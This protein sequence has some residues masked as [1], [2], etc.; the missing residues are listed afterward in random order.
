MTNGCET[1]IMTKQHTSKVQTAKIKYIKQ[2]GERSD[3][4]DRSKNDYIGNELEAQS[5]LDY[6]EQRQPSW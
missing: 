1:W 3:Y 4:Q 5:V 6:A 2:A